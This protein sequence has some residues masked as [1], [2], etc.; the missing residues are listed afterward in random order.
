MANVLQLQVNFLSE[1]NHDGEYLRALQHETRPNNC[2]LNTGM[3]Q[4]VEWTM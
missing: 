2:D 1:N 4:C 3:H